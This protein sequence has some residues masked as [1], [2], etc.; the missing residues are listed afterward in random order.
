MPKK[1]QGKKSPFDF[2]PD[3]ALPLPKLSPTD[4]KIT[5]KKDYQNDMSSNYQETLLKKSFEF[6]NHPK[7]SIKSL[8]NNT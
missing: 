1:Y 5:N 3:I 7:K 4:P 2:K 8:K 6:S